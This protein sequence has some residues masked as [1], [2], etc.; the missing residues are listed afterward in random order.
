MSQVKV[1]QAD[2]NDYVTY[3]FLNYFKA[4]SCSLS[5]DNLLRPV[6]TANWEDVMGYLN[7]I[8]ALQGWNKYRL[9]SEAEWEYAYRAGGHTP[10]W[11]GADGSDATA[12]THAW[13]ANNSGNITNSANT[14]G[15]SN[16]WG[17]F[18]MAG[19]VME[20]CADNYQETYDGVP[21]DG[22]PF[23]KP[24]VSYRVVRG[25]AWNDPA[26]NLR[27]SLRN[28]LLQTQALRTTGFRIVMPDVTAP[29]IMS[30]TATPGSN[31]SGAATLHWTLAVPDGCTAYVDGVVQSGTSLAVTGTIGTPVTHT[32]VVEN[33]S[34][35]SMA[36]VKVVM[37]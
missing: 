35:W 27:A 32:L 7:T 28:D 16:A 4:A 23:L 2:W 26:L 12:S 29:R 8:N 9:P 34:G 14:T 19:N 5:G 11:W 33:A 13:Y 37:P 30:F 15:Q 20:W 22:T 3:P 21:A 31:G 36:A 1:R 10:Y 17:L 6:E 24:S 25:G 18:E